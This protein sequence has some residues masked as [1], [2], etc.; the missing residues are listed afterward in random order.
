MQLV[1]WVGAVTVLLSAALRAPPA[2]Q[3]SPAAVGHVALIRLDDMERAAEL[4]QKLHFCVFANEASDY[5]YVG[6]QYGMWSEGSFELSINGQVVFTGAV[7]YLLYG[8]TILQMGDVIDGPLDRNARIE[9][10]RIS[11]MFK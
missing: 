10:T 1:I 3:P 11:G 8:G 7:P 5:I 4:R 9:I 6:T 2:S